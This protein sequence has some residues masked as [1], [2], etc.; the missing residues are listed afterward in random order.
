MIL[1]KKLTGFSLIE[2]LIVV[3][4][5]SILSALCIPL[6]SQHFVR[7]KRLEAEITLSKLALAMENYYTVH[8]S[9]EE[10][11]LESLGF[12]EKIAG[13]RYQLAIIKATN[14]EF[15][16]AAAPLNNQAEKDSRCGTLILNSTGEKN[17]SGTGLVTDCW[18]S[19]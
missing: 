4:I 8:N 14:N 12:V 7:E 16:L 10:A 6:Y 11:S 17:I 1:S 5:I 3:A 19:S 15:E 2:L 13:D 9:Y 18:Q